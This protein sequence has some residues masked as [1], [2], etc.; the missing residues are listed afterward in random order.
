MRT[1]ATKATHLLATPQHL[2]ITL[3][4][5]QI[6][7]QTN[8]PFK[9]LSEV[10]LPSDL[11]VP[12]SNQSEMYRIYAVISHRGGSLDGGHY[13]TWARALDEGGNEVWRAYDDAEV[14]T[15]SW[16]DLQKLLGRGSEDTPYVLFYE[17]VGGGESGDESPAPHVKEMVDKDN[18]EFE[19]KKQAANMTAGDHFCFNK[20]RIY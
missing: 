3:N 4:R 6:D 7:Q 11:C 16:D 9:I 8:K 19:G 20:K 5:F 14:T 12:G 2:T 15:H 17:R 18:A 10:Q 1:A 13:C